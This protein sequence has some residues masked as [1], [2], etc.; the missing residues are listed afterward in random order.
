[1]FRS[2]LTLALVS[3]ALV[4]AQDF[5][6]NSRLVLLDVVVRG[7]NGAPVK[8]LEREDFTLTDK[9]KKVELAVFETIEL[10]KSAAPVVQ[11]NSMVGANRLNS[12][13]ETQGTATILVYDKVN[14]PAA[15]QGFV[16]NQI[17][18]LMGGLKPA[19][20][21]GFYVLGFGLAPVLEFDEDAAPLIAAAK[22][23]RQLSSADGLTGIEKSLFEAL[24][25]MQELQPQ[26]RV[27]ITYP[28]FRSIANR[29]A[30][31][32]GRKNVVWFAS[33]F[34]LTFG[35]SQERRSDDEKE[36]A[37]FA[38]VLNEAGVAL[39]P[40]DPRGSG[41]GLDTEVVR[42]T[43]GAGIR[44]MQTNT[45]NS[46]SGN[47][48]FRQAAE[49]TG[50]EAFYNTND[51]AGAVRQVLD[52]AAYSYTL[53]YYPDEKSL[54]GKVHK[55]EI[56]LAK[57]P[58]TDKAKLAYRPQYIAW[59]G[60]NVLDPALAQKLQDVVKE[61]LEASGIGLM[62]VANPDPAKPG[63]HK[64]DVQV[65]LADLEMATVGD[66]KA[67]AFELGLAVEGAQDRGAATES[68]A[69]KMT[70]EQYTQFLPSG[71]VISKSVQTDGTSG[72][73]IVVVQD[74][75]TGK[76]GSVR[77]PFASQPK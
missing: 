75:T 19:D 76:V 7:N 14:T 56:K 67:G 51:L 42:N 59:G 47:Q 71:I 27:N 68:F 33:R 58:E 60:K 57:K 55:L 10:G 22:R 25:P 61:P 20:R 32:P 53:G 34:P 69:P 12:K 46:L 8:N 43:E 15:N 48:G 2:I 66:G 21:F 77:V 36:L 28:S 6:S 26:A 1:M 45:A 70:L 54:D 73:F 29:L 39:Y 72:R 5:T 63:F 3:T 44:T 30:G 23:V 9:G 74:K 62:G 13:G 24:L 16:R 11:V 65:S 31:V 17:L 64:L 18:D 35:N 50:G 40:V 37:K 49:M 52:A 4:P 38:N 41:A